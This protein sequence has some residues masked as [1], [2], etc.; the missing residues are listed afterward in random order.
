MHLCSI[1]KCTGD[2]VSRRIF[3]FKL[4]TELRE[5]YIVEISSRNATI[6]RTHSLSTAP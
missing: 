6:A 4:A 3:L 1:K 5:D 2:K